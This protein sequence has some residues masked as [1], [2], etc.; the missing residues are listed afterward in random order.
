[1]FK[2]TQAPV[3]KPLSKDQPPDLEEKMKKPVLAPLLS[4]EIGDKKSES[5]VIKLL[6]KNLKWSQIIYEQ[7]RRINR[8]L[9]WSAAA[10]WL[11]LL[12]ILVPLVLAILFLPPFV[13]SVWN[14]YGGI[15]GT[16]AKNTVSN[17][18]AS[19]LD[20][21]LEMLPLDSA[22]REQLKAILK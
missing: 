4:E 19:S 10:S 1:M 17:P 12:I 16:T 20:Q 2:H 21:L 22:K 14:K 7:N 18:T 3:E 11:R 6:E 5:D 9:V 15:L 13:Q 8:K